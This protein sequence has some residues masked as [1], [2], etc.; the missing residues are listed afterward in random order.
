[1][2]TENPLTHRLSAEGAVEELRVSE[3]GVRT[4]KHQVHSKSKETHNTRKDSWP[5]GVFCLVEALI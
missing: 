5:I 4:W 2:G 3:E 1:M